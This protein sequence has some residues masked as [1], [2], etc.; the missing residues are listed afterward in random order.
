MA[1]KTPWD[2]IKA[3]SSPK[4][5]DGYWRLNEVRFK[6]PRTQKSLLLCLACLPDPPARADRPDPSLKENVQ[7]GCSEARTRF[8]VG[9]DEPEDRLMLLIQ[10]A[11]GG[12]F[13]ENPVRD[14]RQ[15]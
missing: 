6:I 1:S 5:T 11:A 7:G 14:S 10:N 8:E 9:S 3:D 13:A 2:R 12:R 15:W 4:G